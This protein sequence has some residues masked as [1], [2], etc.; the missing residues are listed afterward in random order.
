MEYVS[1][2][3]SALTMGI[4]SHIDWAMSTR[5]NGSRLMEGKPCD[6][7]AVLKR[8]RQDFKQIDRQLASHKWQV[9]RDHSAR[10][11]GTPKTL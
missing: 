5:S 11:L 6:F 8:Q 10:R 9:R 7:I 1:N 4:C 3:V 2:A